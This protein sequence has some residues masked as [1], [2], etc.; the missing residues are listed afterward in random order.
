MKVL[1]KVSIVMPCFNAEATLAESVQGII[2]QTFR[3]WELLLM[4]DGG[5]DGTAVLAKALA[6]QDD[7]IR[8]FISNKNRGVVR[9]R[10]LGIRL[11]TGEWL[12]FCDADDVWLPEKLTLQLQVAEQAGANLVCSSFQFINVLGALGTVVHTPKQI[13][14]DTLLRTNPIPMSTAIVRLVGNHYFVAVPKQLIHED[15][16]YW[17]TMFQKYPIIAQNM[18]VVTTRIRQVPG[19]RSANKWLAAKSHGYILN[20][21][22][23]QKGLHWYLL[24]ISYLFN[25]VLKR[26]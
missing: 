23:G 15:Y 7:R 18:Q 3:N 17:L 16:A 25:G 14:S 2:N 1:G 12:G 19:S 8:V 26:L 9:S 21:Y 11:A 4:V 6:Q 10:N 24:M 22:G 5:G 13:G 20:T